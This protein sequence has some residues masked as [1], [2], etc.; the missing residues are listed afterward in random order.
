MTDLN[1]WSAEVLM[2][3]HLTDMCGNPPWWVKYGS[4][5]Q[6]ELTALPIRTPYNEDGEPMGWVQDDWNPI[7][8]ATGQIWMC[9]NKMEE[10]GWFVNLE[11]NESYP[12]KGKKYQASFYHNEF[13]FIPTSMRGIEDDNPCTAI[14]TA[15]K[16]AW[17]RGGEG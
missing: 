1:R 15:A 3:W 14:L 2:G 11:G 9:V 17:E 13:G 7:D 5:R 6:P 4:P 10:L 16:A 8:P 12:D